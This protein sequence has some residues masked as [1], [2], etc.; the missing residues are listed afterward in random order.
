MS[1]TLTDGTYDGMGSLAL[2]VASRLEAGARRLQS[3]VQDLEARIEN[4]RGQG[5]G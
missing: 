4:G 5:F 2:N 3:K 1:Q